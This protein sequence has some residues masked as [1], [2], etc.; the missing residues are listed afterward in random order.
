MADDS[1][2]EVKQAVDIVQVVG[3]RVTLQKAGRNHKGLCP[4]HGEKSPSFFVSSEMQL[5]KCFGC[6]VSGDVYAFLQAYEGWSFGEALRYLA[7]RAGITLETGRFARRDDE[8]EK[9]LQ[10][11]RAAQEYYVYLLASHEVGSVGRKYFL[12]RGVHGQQQRDFGLGYA[13]ESWH[14]LHDYLV[15]KRRYPV[16][17]I[18]KSGLI[19]SGRRGYYDRFR[20]RVVFPQYDFAGHVVGFS[21]RILGESKEAKYVNTPETPVYHKGDILYGMNQ[22][23]SAIR[24]QDMVVVVEGEMDVL[25]SHRAKVRNCVAVKGS[26]LTESQ[27]LY[28]RRLTKR[29]VLCLDADEAGQKAM[30]RAIPIAEKQGMHLRVV[31]IGAGKDPDEVVRSDPAAWRTMVKQSMSVYQFYIDYA[32]GHY[33]IQTGIGQKEMSAFLA[34]ILGHIQN[35]VEK[36]F[37]MRKLADI[38]GAS[39]N[40][41]EQLVA[42]ASIAQ[43]QGDRRVQD[44]SEQISRRERV[45]RYV[46]GVM[47]HLPVERLR[48]SELLLDWYFGEHYLAQLWGWIRE[49][50][51]GEDRGVLMRL[52][53][54]QSEELQGVAQDLYAQ[55]EALLTATSE[56]LWRWYTKSIKELRVIATRERMKTLLHQMGELEPDSSELVRLRDEYQ[57]L[58]AH[59]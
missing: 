39:V 3:E 34:P 20:G 37:Y 4:F 59:L 31:P 8:R 49:I 48:A 6:G 1:V 2:A 25:A 46:L 30:M 56:E 44:E 42:R 7:D 23:K 13:P 5:Y 53:S 29:I 51:D 52:V 55:D 41:V 40:T 19:L 10:I 27:V 22:A 15:H 12:E 50:W 35:P 26:A 18:E 16:E 57:Q 17:M 9:L 58:Q 36:E 47:L 38:L 43:P 54:S 14:S 45:E 32:V 11:L 28:I 21:G 33:D 24:K